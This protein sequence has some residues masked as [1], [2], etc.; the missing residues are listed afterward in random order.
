MPSIIPIETPTM[1]MNTL[2]AFAR[3]PRFHLILGLLAAL[4]PARADDW[5]QWRG[6]ARS[7]ISSEAGLLKEWPEIG[8]K[9]EWQRSD[10]GSGYAAPIVVGERIYVLANAGLEDEFV[11]ALSTHDGAR[12]WR[13][14]LGNVG[15]P[16]QQPKFPAA[17]STPT[18]DGEFLYALG[19][20]G[21]LACVEAA[22]G[23]V[24]WRKSLRTDFGGK[25]GIWAYT[26]SP[27]VD[28]DV[29]V[30]SPGGAVATV[31]ALDKRTGETIWK[32]VTPEADEAAYASA[33]VVHAAGR[34]QYVQMLQKGL[35]GL[36]AETGKLLWRHGQT[37]S[38]FNANIP[39]PIAQGDTIYSAG[40]GTGGGV[41]RLV[42]KDGSVAVAPGYFSAKLPT[43]IGGAVLV[44]E[45]LYGT[46]GQAMLCVEFATGTVKWEERALGAGSV[47]YADGRLYV[48][49]ENGMVGLV[50]AN[51]TAYV[52]RGRFTPPATPERLSPMEKSWAY[53]VLA[54]GRLYLRDHGSLWCYDVRAN[55]GSAVR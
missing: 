54:E 29:V 45:H 3:S 2:L 32:A 14:R 15:N 20:D 11:Q 21:D 1:P 47:L 9:L 4:I 18:F 22:N 13:T 5:P 53:P 23:E 8:P 39:S 50:D 35:V 19:S 40:A 33:I 25:P 42:A 34:K 52:E 46:T 38:K 36:D 44:G 26:E 16:E 27:L 48:H 30:C 10:I 41:V 51:P 49:G 37:V 7:G 6:P 55:P 43:A 24:R 12:L 28:G 17:R 31:V